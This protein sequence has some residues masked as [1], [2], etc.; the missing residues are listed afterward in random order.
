MQP[1]YN[2]FSIMCVCVCVCVYTD[3]P[4]FQIF[5]GKIHFSFSIFMIINQA[6]KAHRG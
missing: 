3:F 1:L 6:F 5:S 4:V 2:T